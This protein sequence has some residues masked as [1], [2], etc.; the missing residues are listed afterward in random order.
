MVSKG[1]FRRHTPMK[2][3]ISYRK[4]RD[5]MLKKFSSPKIVEVLTEATIRSGICLT[6]KRGR[7]CEI[8]KRETCQLCYFC[9][10]V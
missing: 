2:P 4:R 3:N 5:L 7:P 8:K 9:T 10:Y 6:F 1:W